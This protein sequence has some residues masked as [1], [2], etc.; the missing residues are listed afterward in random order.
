MTRVRVS[1]LAFGFAALEFVTAAVATDM[2]P[3]QCSA[4]GR[5]NV[6]ELARRLLVV[7]LLELAAWV[8]VFVF[9]RHQEDVPFVVELR[10]GGPGVKVRR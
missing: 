9:Y 10:D 1:V 7:S 4:I 8:A 6:H 3:T 5:P 2:L